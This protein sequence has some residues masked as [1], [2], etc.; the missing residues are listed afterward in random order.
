MFQY[1]THLPSE[2]H[3]LNSDNAYPFRAFSAVLSPRR[4]SI[5]QT[6]DL[7]LNFDIFS[8]DN[9]LIQHSPLSYPNTYTPEF[10]KDMDLKDQN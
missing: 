3:Y 9:F 1:F 2:Q 4:D 5:L 7:D 8:R 6:M 10:F